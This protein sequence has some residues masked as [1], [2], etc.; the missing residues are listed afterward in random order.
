ML[1]NLCRD[2]ESGTLRHIFDGLTYDLGVIS[3]P[4]GTYPSFAFTPDDTGIIIWAAGQIYRV[5]LAVNERGER[6][7]GTEPAHTIPF[8][9]HIEKR[10]ADTL[11]PKTD[12][13]GLE[14]AE[15]QKVY[16][17]KNLRVNTKGTKAV[18]T[19]AGQ[20]YFQ[21][22]FDD[23]STAQRIPALYPNAPYYAPT[24]VHGSDDL[25]L[26]ARW[27]D[28]TFTTFEIANIS[29]GAAYEIAGVPMG[30]YISPVL[31]ECT[32]NSRVIAFVKSGGDYLTGDVVATAGAGLYI[33][34]IELPSSSSGKLAVKNSRLIVTDQGSIQASQALKLRFLQG[35]DKLLVQQSDKA[36]VVDLAAGGDQ[37]GV[38][39][40]QALATGEMSTELVLA[41][42]VSKSTGNVELENL[43]FVDFFH[44]YVVTG[45]DASK[46][47]SPVWSK[48]GKAPQGL[49]RLSFDG[50]HDITWSGDGKRLF[51]FLGESD[52]ILEIGPGFN[53]LISTRAVLTLNRGFHVERMQLR[54]T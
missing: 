1:T 20:T 49:T 18:F 26:H 25:V 2:L 16:A 36:F 34:E 17:F 35:A 51:W 10:I 5:P 14:T 52:T 40:T 27:S 15:T 3:A 45:R 37:F 46:L 53:Q 31:C 13:L 47:D 19:A 4:M 23:Y 41:P 48:P 12:I 54:H 28:S 21:N 43:A 6:V 8:T 30:R 22:I 11:S 39:K 38:Y 24:F 50:G 9:A 7:A 33:A 32:G 42:R 29:S 44:V